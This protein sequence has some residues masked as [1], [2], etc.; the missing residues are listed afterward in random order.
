MDTRRAPNT[1]ENG[2]KPELGTETVPVELVELQS[3][4][5]SGRGVTRMAL[6][7]VAAIGVVAFAAIVATGRPPTP[8]PPPSAPAIGLA[9]ATPAPTPTPTPTV[10]PGTFR[11]SVAPPTPRPTPPPPWQWVRSDFLPDLHASVEGIWGVNGNILALIRRYD[12]TMDRDSWSIARQV[13][14]DGWELLPAPPAID[15]FFAGTVVD[16]RLWFFARVG[17]ITDADTTWQLINTDDGMTWDS[18]GTSEGL[19]PFDAATTLARTG[20]SWVIVTERARGEGASN[21]A[22]S[23]SVDGRHWKLADV[24]AV[25]ANVGYTDAA[26]IGDATVMVG[27]DFDVP[28]DTGWFAMRST[29][30]RAWQ[31]TSF[32]VPSTSSARDLACDDRVCIITLH[33]FGAEAASTQTIMVSTDGDHW[34]EVA[35]NVPSNGADATI[36]LLATT[37]TGF[38]ALTGSPAQALLSTDGSL[39]RAVEVLPPDADAY[40]SDLAV[41]G[42]QVVALVPW[43]TSDDP[44]FRIWVGSLAAMGIQRR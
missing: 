14:E 43:Q 40:I 16:D 37:A 31:R 33:A 10:A 3:V 2:S 34:A 6:L 22:I 41:A 23:W 36:G 5:S 25:R 30:G 28:E 21:G 1:I 39:W 26:S 17:G 24:P 35:V 13:G 32:A 42:D 9:S 27:F 11:P 19:P 18:L 38:I 44:I 29:D 20:D 15:D 7:A 4:G 12:S 8:T